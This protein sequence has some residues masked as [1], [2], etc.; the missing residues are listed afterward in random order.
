MKLGFEWH[1]RPKPLLGTRNC[2]GLRNQGC[3]L[4]L[5]L[6][7][8]HLGEGL[9]LTAELQLQASVWNDWPPLP[10]GRQAGPGSLRNRK[11]GTRRGL[12]ASSVP[13]SKV[14]LSTAYWY[15][16]ARGSM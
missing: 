1:C 3:G 16:R 2:Q 5:E 9:D 7:M 13:H 10:G 6:T 15:M 12:G 11:G 4:G 8:A 14:G